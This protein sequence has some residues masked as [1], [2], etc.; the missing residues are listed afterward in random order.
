[1]Q[2]FIYLP[3]R[4]VI[5]PGRRLTTGARPNVYRTQQLI[6]VHYPSREKGRH[7]REN[8]AFYFFSN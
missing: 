3:D 7:R 2:E 8:Q 5:N 6:T 4:G 1:M